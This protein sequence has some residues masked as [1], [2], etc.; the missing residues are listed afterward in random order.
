MVRDN[1]LLY[2]FALRIFM[3][4]TKAKRYT[5]HLLTDYHQHTMLFIP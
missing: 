5:D 2:P 1:M 4:Q 3:T